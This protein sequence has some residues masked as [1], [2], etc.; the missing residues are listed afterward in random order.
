MGVIAGSAMRCVH[1]SHKDPFSV[2]LLSDLLLSLPSPFPALSISLLPLPNTACA[3]THAFSFFLKC[4]LT[5]T[6]LSPHKNSQTFTVEPHRLLDF[7][8][9]KRDHVSRKLLK[10]LAALYLLLLFVS[11]FYN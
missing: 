3:G 11:S 1:I 6:Q 10:A 4:P 7:C 8:I 5:A 9:R 2:G